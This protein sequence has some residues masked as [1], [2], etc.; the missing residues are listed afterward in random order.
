MLQSPDCLQTSG[1]ARSHPWA[2]GTYVKSN[3]KEEAHVEHA[4]ND[5]AS[6][7]M[8]SKPRSNKPNNS[9]R[10]VAPAPKQSYK[11]DLSRYKAKDCDTITESAPDVAS[12]AD[13]VAT[14]QQDTIRTNWIKLERDQS[15]MTA[16]KPS[17]VG[18]VNASVGA[19]LHH[20]LGS[21]Q[22]TKK[23]WCK[24]DLSQLPIVS[25]I[26][27]QKNVLNDESWPALPTQSTATKLPK[28]DLKQSV[29][30]ILPKET[31]NSKKKKTKSTLQ[32][33]SC[34]NLESVPVTKTKAELLSTTTTFPQEP[35][36]DQ[37]IKAV[38]PKKI[39]SADKKNTLDDISCQGLESTQISKTN[40]SRREFVSE[41]VRP[42]SR[43]MARKLK[44]MGLRDART[45]DDTLH[46]EPAEK[47]NASTEMPS[48]PKAS[49]VAPA[50]KQLYKVDLS[51][52][53]AKDSNTIEVSAL[54]DASRAK[55][56][57][58]AQ[59]DTT[60]TNWIKLERDQSVMVATKLSIGQPVREEEEGEGEGEDKMSQVQKE[61]IYKKMMTREEFLNWLE[62]EIF[63]EGMLD[64]VSKNWC[65]MQ[66]D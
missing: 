56:V 64:S 14:A 46:A 18:R 50:P 17:K 38:V 7:K 9:K 3:S 39:S 23:K 63:E 20:E 51:R 26:T 16:T 61:E 49:R 1:D 5:D 36:S 55:V 2:R 32:D 4:E 33:T 15:V 53:K 62:K 25:S 59:Q 11:V 24:L 12:W 8:P 41:D 31:S 22:T 60:K 27:V 48:K 54:D 47:A 19:S 66:L 52:Y 65:L 29:N 57:A 44:K 34:L 28:A 42:I 58:T 30:A 21:T 43:K 45:D 40:G 37:Q 35:D 6:M 13:V 10:K